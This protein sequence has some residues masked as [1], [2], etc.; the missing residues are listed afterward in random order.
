MAQAKSPRS[1]LMKGKFAWLSLVFWAVGLTDIQ[2]QEWHFQP[3]PFNT[4][5]SEVLI[6]FDGDQL[7]FSRY[8]GGGGLKALLNPDFEAV[9]FVASR[10]KG[11]TG[12]SSEEPMDLMPKEPDGME[13]LGPIGHVAVDAD[14]GVMVGS[15]WTVKGGWDLFVAHRTTNGDWAHPRLLDA[16]NTRADEVFPNFCEGDIWF[17]SNRRGSQGGFDVFVSRRKAQW[18]TVEWAPEGVNSP[19]D[20]IAAVCAGEEEAD[21]FYVC[22]SRFGGQGASDIG[23][24]GPVTLEVPSGVGFITLEVIHD[25]EPLAGVEVSVKRHGEGGMH[26][27]RG[28]TGLAGRVNI[29]AM[30]LDAA[31]D[32]QVRSVK[33]GMPLPDLS[34]L[35]VYQTDSKTGKEE[36]IRTYR[37]EGGRVFVFDFLPLDALGG[38]GVYESAEDA[39]GLLLSADPWVVQFPS[40]LWSL[41]D[42][43]AIA[44]QRWFAPWSDLMPGVWP[45]A[46]RLKVVG[47]ADEQGDL[48]FNDALGL[49]RAQSVADWIMEQGVPSEYIEVLSVGERAASGLDALDRR[50]EVTWT[51]VGG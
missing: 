29:G 48:N 32:I 21:G 15:T 34:F 36:R 35:H 10:A 49:K 3:L 45:E 2:G 4:S 31:H 26:A 16:L 19:A 6:G 25:L 33:P 42:R 44:G 17:G 50:C 13:S 7:Y 28:L 40:G 43:D 39:S 9:G 18:Q 46:W 11:F 12:F 41:S 24:V 5:D 51:R 30:A 23:Y 1:G 38:L 8:A 47:F 27:F 22:T 37:I 14:R 20:D